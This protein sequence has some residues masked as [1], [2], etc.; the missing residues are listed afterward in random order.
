MIGFYGASDRA[1]FEIERRCMDRDGVILRH[2]E[3][4]L[5]LGKLLEIGGGDGF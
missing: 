3:A 2:L 5:P 4:V 1:T